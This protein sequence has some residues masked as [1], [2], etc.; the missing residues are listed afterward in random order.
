[1]KKT[2]NIL[3][4]KSDGKY[5]FIKTFEI[6]S[7]Y[8]SFIDTWK[9]ANKICSEIDDVTDTTLFQA[10]SDKTKFGFVSYSCWK[11]K[12]AFIKSNL[13]NTV[14]GYHNTLNGS[15]ARSATQYLYK[16]KSTEKYSG[17]KKKYYNAKI[18]MIETEMQ[19]DDYIIEYWKT[20]CTKENI[21]IQSSFLYKSIYKDAKVRFIGVLKYK[22]NNS[23]YEST[24]KN[25][26][27]EAKKGIK[28][29]S[30]FFKTVMRY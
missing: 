25:L 3:K 20:V 8:T 9:I 29:Y 15:E 24:L 12:E 4:I 22:D 6:V 30:L 7:T 19:K 16:L 21:N 26:L 11:S 27:F 14:L 13:E 28:V 2:D 18:F 17:A 23:N 10:H 1:M 5:Y